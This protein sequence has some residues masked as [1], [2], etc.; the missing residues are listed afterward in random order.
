MQ[1]S[2]HRTTSHRHSTF[3]RAC[4]PDDGPA[5][6]F[7]HGWPE[8]S[9]SWRHQLTY[10]GSLGYRVIAPDMRGYGGS[11]L[12]DTHQAYAQTE[13]VQDM[14]ELIDHLQ[15]QQAV[16]IGHDWGSPVAWNMALHHPDR[17]AAVASL[18]VPFG[19]A[20][21]PTQMEHSINRQL[22]PA[23][24]YPVGQWDYQ[25]FYY[26]DFA[27]AQAE[28]ELDP[29]A[30]I[31]LLFRK[32]DPAGQGLP[33]GTASTRK[34]QGWFT[35][36]GGVPD[37]P[38]DDDVVS[39]EDVAV[40]AGHLQQN[41]F[42]GPNSWYVNGAAN[43]SFLDSKASATLTMPVLFVHA[44][45]DYVCDTTTTNFAEPMRARCPNLTEQRIDCGH[46]MAQ[47]KP[48]ELNAILETWLSQQVRFPAHGSNP[49]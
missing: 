7:T 41:G 46:W 13:I 11:S 38:R 8:L 20:G 17:V 26:E 4:G 47:E 37:M 9:I 24:E 39:A 3:Y 19:F 30:L 42:F 36:L 35:Q 2:E 6:I 22:Y 27:K 21:N 49:G 33:A 32:G 15:I 40:Y 18:C 5:I 28:M 31:K 45:Y 1:I 48:Q 12:Y 16:W 25:L 34:N 14:L 29:E 43:Q 10:L 44:T 23:A